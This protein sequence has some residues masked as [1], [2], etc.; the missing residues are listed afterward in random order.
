M[1]PVGA[2]LEDRRDPGGNDGAGARRVG[3]GIRRV[4]HDAG[5]RLSVRPVRF[6]RRPREKNVALPFGVRARI[7]AKGRLFLLDSPVEA[8]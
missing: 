3:G 5:R 2:A 4:F 7:D 8:G 1:G 6:S